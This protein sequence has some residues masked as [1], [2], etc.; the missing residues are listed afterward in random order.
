MGVIMWMIIHDCCPFLALI[1][2]EDKMFI[3][4]TLLQKSKFR[5]S[6]SAFFRTA[7]NKIHSDLLRGWAQWACT[8][9]RT[10]LASIKIKCKKKVTMKLF[11]VKDKKMQLLNIFWKSVGLGNEMKYYCEGAGSHVAWRGNKLQN[12]SCKLVHTKVF[13]SLH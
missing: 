1:T 11:S 6:I 12:C 2:F 8:T 4:I 9:C 3:E 10:A 5:Y 7:D 13:F